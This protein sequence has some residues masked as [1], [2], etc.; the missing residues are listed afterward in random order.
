MDE[1]ILPIHNRPLLV[2]EEAK[3]TQIAVHQTSSV[4]GTPYR[5]MFLGTG[6]PW[7]EVA[8]SNTESFCLGSY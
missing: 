5:V 6:M 2:K 1:T 3:Y 4:A 8:H 7:V